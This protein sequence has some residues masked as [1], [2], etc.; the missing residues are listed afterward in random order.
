MAFE[1]KWNFSF[2]DGKKVVERGDFI[3]SHE[4]TTDGDFVRIISKAFTDTL[5]G[6]C[7]NRKD[8][9]AW[10]EQEGVKVGK[11]FEVFPVEIKE[12]A[13]AA[14][15]APVPKPKPKV[16]KGMTTTENIK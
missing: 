4:N 13:K 3:K 2:S 9:V 1:F 10:I 5:N 14:S 15:P 11:P 16:K 12:T 7:G 8:L 6:V